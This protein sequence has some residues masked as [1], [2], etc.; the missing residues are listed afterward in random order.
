MRKRDSDWTRSHF[1]GIESEISWAEA[2][3]IEID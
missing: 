3:W 2:N 1:G